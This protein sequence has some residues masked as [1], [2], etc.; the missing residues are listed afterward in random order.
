VPQK[1]TADKVMRA[2]FGLKNSKFKTQN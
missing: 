2:K 1:Y